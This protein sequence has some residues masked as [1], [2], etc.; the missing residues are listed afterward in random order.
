MH[1]IG[2]GLVSLGGTVPKENQPSPAH[3][4]NRAVPV[5]DMHKQP[6]GLVRTAAGQHGI[7]HAEAGQ[8]DHSGVPPRVG[9]HRLVFL[10]DVTTHEADD[11]LVTT[12]LGRQTRRIGHLGVLDAKRRRLPGLPSHQLVEIGGPRRNLLE[13][14]QRHFRGDVRH[15]QRHASRCA[16]QLRQHPAHRLTNRASVSD[17]GRVGRRCQRAVRQRLGDDGRHLAAGS[18]GPIRAR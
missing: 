6:V 1:Q 13:C 3:D 11:E 10:D 9:A 18:T 5:G 17:V 16:R 12:L 4:G 8:V 2:Q 14:H 15:H 7:D